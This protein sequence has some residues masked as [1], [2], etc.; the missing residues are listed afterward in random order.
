MR[1]RIWSNP[2]FFAPVLLLWLT[3]L[4]LALWLPY[5]TEILFF[6]PWRREPFNTFF[7][8]AT[9]LGEGVAFAGVAVTAL[10]LRYRFS[11]L[12]AL[13]GLL[14]MPLV[15]VLKDQAAYDRPLTYFQQKG[16]MGAVVTVPGVELRSGKTSF[17][18]GHTMAAFT[19]FGLLN[20]MAARR[21]PRLGLLFALMAALTGIS[22]IFLVQHFLADI[23]AGAVLGLAC[24][25]LIWWLD[26]RLLP[27]PRT[28]FL[29]KGALRVRK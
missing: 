4:A 2:W 12:V 10:L 16:A 18:S 22:R 8:L 1:Q 20:L 5:G 11:L 27:P 23:L 6:N 14:V 17:P 24:A 21:Y 28:A 19:L 9:H 29:D 13:G 15:Y 7:K 25:Q 26:H 3:G